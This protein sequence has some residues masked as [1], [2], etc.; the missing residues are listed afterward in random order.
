MSTTTNG[1]SEG[2]SSPTAPANDSRASSSPE[3]TSASTP[4]VARTMPKKSSRLRASR[5]AL[6]ATIRTRSV[7][8]R[9][10]TAV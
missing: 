8:L 10:S 5:V 1:P 2:S 9:R 4:R 7:P 6:V 3:I